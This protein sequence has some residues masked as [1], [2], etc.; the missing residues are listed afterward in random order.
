MKKASTSPS[1]GVDRFFM[2]KA[3]DLGLHVR[4]PR[5]FSK[6]VCRNKELMP[7]AVL[8]MTHCKFLLLNKRILMKFIKAQAAE[9]P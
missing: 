7:S 2:S 3:R 5:V 9:E 1:E 6:G 8:A 4:G